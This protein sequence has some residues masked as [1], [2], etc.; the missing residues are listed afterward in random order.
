MPFP[1]DFTPDRSKL[2]GSHGQRPWFNDELAELSTLFRYKPLVKEKWRLGGA[3]LAQLDGCRDNPI[4]PCYFASG[5]NGLSVNV[6]N[7]PR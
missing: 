2:Y 1:S 7:W 5:A 4:D 6:E 3:A